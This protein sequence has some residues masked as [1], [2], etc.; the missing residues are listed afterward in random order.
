MAIS[1]APTKYHYSRS[2][3]LVSL[4]TFFI[5]FLSTLI[6]RCGTVSSMLPT[7]LQSRRQLVSQAN[8]HFSASASSSSSNTIKTGK[9]SGKGKVEFQGDEHSVPSG[10]N[11]ISNR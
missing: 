8:A 2:I 3:L 5:F 9:N 10:P 7:N 6:L 4:A 11:P 1:R